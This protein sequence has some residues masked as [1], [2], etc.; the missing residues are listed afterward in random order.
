MCGATANHHADQAPFS[1]VHSDDALAGGETVGEVHDA[2]VAVEFRHR[3][4]SAS[5][6]RVNLSNRA[7]GCPDRSGVC[8]HPRSPESM[9]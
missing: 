2:I 5:Q 8:L 7:Q 6:P 1:C 4:E 9:P 3:D